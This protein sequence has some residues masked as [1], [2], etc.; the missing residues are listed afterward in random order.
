MIEVYFN[1]GY[2]R[3]AVKEDSD[4]SL[5]LTSAFNLLLFYSF[6]IFTK[7]TVKR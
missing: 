7:N 1:I 2:D 3:S 4:L 6:V 5:R